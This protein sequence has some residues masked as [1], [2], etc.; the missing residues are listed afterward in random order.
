[1]PATTIA[2][3]AGTL[4]SGAASGAVPAAFSS[5]GASMAG[6]IGGSGIGWGDVFNVGL[7]Y[8]G[9]R[10]AANASQDAANAQLAFGQK[11]L[12]ENARQYD[13][14][15]QDYLANRDF[16]RQQMQGLNPYMQLGTSTFG[17]LGRLTGNPSIGAPQPQQPMNLGTAGGGVRV[18]TG[19]QGLPR[20]QLVTVQGPD[21][22]TR[23]VPPQLAQIAIA[24]GAKVL[25]G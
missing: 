11:A 3:T 23:Q 17:N 6:G 16:T 14:S 2:P 13:T 20:A 21:G 4:A 8:L 12:D 5:G 22:S 10:Q 25:N 18:G 24:Q 9:S 19:Q 1:L 7:N 15:R